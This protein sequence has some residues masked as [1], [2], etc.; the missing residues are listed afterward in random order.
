MDSLHIRAHIV[1]IRAS[2]RQPSNQLTIGIGHMNMSNTGQPADCSYDV[3]I[4]QAQIPCTFYLL[5]YT[6]L[7]VSPHRFAFLIQ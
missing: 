6:F 5:P 7:W 2:G 1:A 4:A 3:I